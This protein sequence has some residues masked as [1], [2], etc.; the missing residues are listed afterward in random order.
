MMRLRTQRR[1]FIQQV[2]LVLAWLAWL[3][4][5][6]VH[7]AQSAPSAGAVI[8]EVELSVDPGQLG[9]AGHVRP[10]TWT[11]LRIE[12]RTHRAEPMEV[13]A[14][15]TLPDDDG[16]RVQYERI[17]TLTPGQSRA[18]WLYGR[19]TFSIRGTEPWS[20]EVVEVDAQGEPTRVLAEQSI[21]P[22]ASRLLAPQTSAIAVLGAA[23]VGLSAFTRHDTRHEALA[24]IDGWTLQTLPDR[25]QG[26][27]GLEA[28]VW[29]PVDGGDPL[30]REFTEAAAGALRSYVERGGQ[31]VIVVP[32]AGDPWIGSPLEDL[33]PVKQAGRRIQSASLPRWASGLAIKS[34]DPIPMTVFDVE[35]G[36][37][38]DVIRR[39][40]GQDGQLGPAL[41]VSRRV[42]FGR[43]VQI[44]LDLSGTDLQRVARV[45]GS[46]T[47]WKDVFGW[48]ETVLPAARVESLAQ[49]GSMFPA[50][51][52]PTRD[53]GDGWAGRS[54]SMTAT[55][56]PA[57]VLAILGFALY[58]LVAGLGLQA[59]LKIKRRA[60][61]AWPVFIVGV[62]VFS[63]VAWSLAAVLKPSDRRVAHISV[64][65]FGPTGEV[66]VQSWMSLFLPSFEQA[67]ITLAG[68][69]DLPPSDA[70]LF[71]SPGQDVDLD[72]ARFPDPQPYRVPATTGAVWP[73]I[74]R[75]TS[76]TM[77]VDSVAM[78]REG[79]GG[80]QASLQA[81]ADAQAV[82]TLTHD[83]PGTL[84]QVVV[85]VCPGDGRAGR[86]YTV[87]SAWPAQT[88]ITLGPDPA[89][90]PIVATTTIQGDQRNWSA[91][92]WLGIQVGRLTGGNVRQDT[93]GQVERAL[94][95]SLLG[96]EAVTAS[97]FNMLP[98]P[99]TGLRG[100][101]RGATLQRPLLRGMDLSHLTAGRRVI[102]LGVM[103]NAELPLPVQVGG[104]DPGETDPASLAIVRYVAEY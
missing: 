64:V 14:R 53:L 76:K 15:L 79:W 20:I 8:S 7:H 101:D 71:S 4:F 85:V 94:R 47:V 66:R 52:L 59:G 62:L 81:D 2:A 32:P 21:A 72:A 99:N 41:I 33:L 6:W 57:L 55:A 45:D 24:L 22:I 49:Q 67:P 3:G 39:L 97:F 48:R 17:V 43:V 82:G 90:Q 40:P 91:E 75:A 46:F 74:F 88:P 31:L 16:D 9:W 19:P 65:D 35:P 13:L 36:G 102:V 44:G 60:R 54:L 69:E 34:T 56:T 30:S 77:H 104:R 26:M 100:L 87:S 18:V 1:T 89:A 51:S 103:Q 29:L 61:W 63:V 80:F 23:E 38:V 96:R 93:A 28:M 25:R 86:V 37:P 92:G 42:G 50:S 27:M 98:P 68:A 10:G 5:G 95:P 58:W 12:L 73:A 78:L 11:P 83:L 84:E 70:P